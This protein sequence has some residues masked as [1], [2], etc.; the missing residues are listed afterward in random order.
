MT[1]FT[2][3]NTASGKLINKQCH[4]Y[5]IELNFSDGFHIV[6]PIMYDSSAEDIADQLRFAADR[7]G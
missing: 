1:T 5:G 7:L 3:S 4:N 2:S 6:I